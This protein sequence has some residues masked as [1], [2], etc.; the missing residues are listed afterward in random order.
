MLRNR[1][2]L[3]SIIVIICTDL[4][5]VPTN[6]GELQ[7]EALLALAAMAQVISSWGFYG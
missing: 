3:G 7:N 5:M 6:H 1:T 2:E 4:L